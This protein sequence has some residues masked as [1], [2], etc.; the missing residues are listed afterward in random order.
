VVMPM[1][2]P[3]TE[4]IMED[5]TRYVDIDSI[6]QNPFQPRTHIDPD[7]IEE[8]AASIRKFGV[9]QPL[10]VRECED[11][12]FE[13]IAGQRRVEGSRVAGISQVPVIVKNATDTEMLEM[14]IVEN[15][16]REDMSPIDKAMGFKRLI[17][18]FNLTQNQISNLLGISR[19][20]IANTLRLL[21]LPDNIKN[22]L[23]EKMITEG[24][25]RALLLIKDPEKRSIA[26]KRIVNGNMSVREAEKISKIFANGSKGKNGYE[27]EKIS[28]EE[29]DFI[30]RLR[31]K[32]GTRVSL[33]RTKDGGKIEIEFYSDEHFQ[34]IAEDLF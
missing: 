14:A 16:H 25:A 33:K 31:E 30:E 2:K 26:L 21:D 29:S 13:L 20:A 19:P 12:T 24:H 34:R 10:L 3:E 32:L 23:H 22:A 6:K 11:G 1:M 7:G 15:L 5:S 4:T 8:M 17:T 28:L 18:R 9:L 27:K